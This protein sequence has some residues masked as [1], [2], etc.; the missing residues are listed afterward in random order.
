MTNDSVRNDEA[1]TADD[2]GTLLRN[3]R[4]D[5]GF[6]VVEIAE[7]TRITKSHITALEDNDY[8]RLP[9]IAYIPG[10]IR[11]YCKVVNIDP[12]PLI[13]AYKQTTN[14][15]RD[16]PVYK[17]PV[18]ALVPKMAGS[19]VA[20]FVVVAGL[21]GYIGWNFL[22]EDTASTA[23]I[24]SLDDSSLDNVK[25][26][27]QT[28]A[29]EPEI[30]DPEPAPLAAIQQIQP[31]VENNPSDEIAPAN[32]EIS[33]SV[34]IANAPVETD[35][36]APLASQNS[37]TADQQGD[38]QQIL[39][40]TVPALQAQQIAALAPAEAS[41]STTPPSAN[42]GEAPY[43]QNPETELR[44][45][46]AQALQRNP[47]SEIVISASSTSWVEIVKANGEVVVSKLLRK[48]DN[49][50]ATADTKLF[51]STGNAGGISLKMG[52]Q[53]AVKIGKTGEIIRDLA[54]TR[55]SLSLIRDN[56]QF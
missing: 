38:I 50:V 20:M 56:S 39:E 44:G 5:A 22:Q 4:A 34:E 12:Q 23:Q 7:M 17:F 13:A 9:G 53:K 15:E 45:G 42:I 11:N 1:I 40:D 2:I 33:E 48:G 14:P 41:R 3:A 24:A 35:A 6:S 37:N 30:L 25:R 26:F 16:K 54:L 27:D 52:D 18:Q 19:M 49:F 28:E 8:S 21:A 29:V 51:L 46:A 36:S 32:T 55:D 47:M 43:L 31:E 10:F